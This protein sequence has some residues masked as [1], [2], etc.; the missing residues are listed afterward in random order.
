[1]SKMTDKDTG[2]EPAFPI[3]ASIIKAKNMDE[4]KMVSG[5]TKREYFA[6][7]AMQ[8]MISANY[9]SID[10]GHEPCSKD[11]VKYADA[12]IKELENGSR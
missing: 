7:I 2:D 3:E 1:M 10:P 6:A 11:A 4:F 5:L 9:H 8:G 12:L